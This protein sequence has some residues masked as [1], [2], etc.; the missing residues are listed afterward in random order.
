MSEGGRV[1][2]MPYVLNLLYFEGY[3]TM[4]PSCGSGVG[5]PPKSR[6]IGV[7][8]DESLRGFDTFALLFGI[9]GP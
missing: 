1:Q 4:V 6:L 9:F 2:G 3:V 5:A 8:T 7:S